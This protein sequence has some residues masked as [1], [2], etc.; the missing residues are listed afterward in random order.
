MMSNIQEGEILL[1]EDNKNDKELILRALKEYNLDEKVFSVK[2]GAEALDY[3]FTTGQY[4]RRNTSLPKVIILDLKLPKV[5]GLEVLEA[6]RSHE[7]T[8]LLPVVVFT[9][10]NQEEDKLK[11]YQLGT[12]SFVVKPIDY[13]QFFQAVSQL[14]LYWLLLNQPAL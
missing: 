7:Q 14:G 5:N 12:N 13:E 3:I 8:R 4:A 6:I 1:I 10:S 9:S 2:D 11:S